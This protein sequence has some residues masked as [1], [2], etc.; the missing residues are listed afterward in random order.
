MRDKRQEDIL[1]AMRRADL[2]TPG[3]LM[4]KLHEIDPGASLM[5]ETLTKSPLRLTDAK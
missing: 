3:D 1:E 4:R 5:I 2:D